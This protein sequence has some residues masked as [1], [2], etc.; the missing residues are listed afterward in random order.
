MA[1]G[2]VVDV[3]DD[4]HS[5]SQ[6]PS[7]CYASGC[8]QCPHLHPRLYRRTAG[9]QRRKHE[10][11]PVPSSWAGPQSRLPTTHGA[12]GEHRT[13]VGRLPFR[14]VERDV[15]HPIECCAV[16]YV[17]HFASPASPVDYAAHGI[18]TLRV[19]P[20]GTFESL[21][22]ARRCGAK[23][24]MASTSESYG[25]PLVYPQTESC[26]GRTFNLVRRQ[27]WPCLR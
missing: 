9:A 23:F 25:D 20:Y 5:G 7:T 21:E 11:R 19:R 18:E 27:I 13:S 1:E 26:W 14:V 17:F 15:C 2:L 6:E 22:T 16:D 4:D 12:A 3:A 10:F 24:M 8:A